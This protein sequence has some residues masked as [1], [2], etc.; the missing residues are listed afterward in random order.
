M[1]TIQSNPTPS[2][3]NPGP[4][5]D[6]GS[7]STIMTVAL[8]VLAVL[9]AFTTYSWLSGRTENAQLTTTL[10]E[11][12]EFKAQAEQQYYE[13]LAELEEMRGD[14]EEL[15]A[16]I[17][18]QKAELKMSKEKID[19]LT[20]DSRNLA[21]ARRELKDLRT[22]VDTYIAELNQLREENQLLTDANTELTSERDLLST[23]LQSV[24]QENESLNEARAVLVSERDQLSTEKEQLSR[25]V[26][27]GSV[28]SVANLIAEGQKQR[29]SGK[30]VSRSAAKNVD[31]LY[32]CFNTEE[33]RVAETG[34]EVY[35]L[36]II[37]P[38]G[39]TINI[40]AE[41]GGALRSEETGEMIA[42][43]KP[44]SFEFDG[45]ATNLCTEWN[46]PSQ[47]YS[48]GVYN[49]ELYN[50]GYLAGSTTLELK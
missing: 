30:Y 19:G 12:E 46:V 8:V 29:N 33:N 40:A 1:A 7:K 34:E 48:E 10:S 45:A 44:V 3:P 38:T 50:K 32:I 14:N 42:Y 2:T 25:K 6:N 36:R 47:S 37:N 28:I 35:Y 9:L 20:R 16:L 15:N 31:R 5:K 17:D 22:Q 41:G 4:K 43:T 27:A 24:R 13:A 49:I 23:D 18:Q 39:E 11:T 26:T 21:A